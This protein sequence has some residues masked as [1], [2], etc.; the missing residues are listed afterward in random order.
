MVRMDK[1]GLPYP[2]TPEG[3]GL[4]P[5]LRNS[6]FLVGLARSNARNSGLMLREPLP[7]P[8]TRPS[9]FER[10][11]IQP[12]ILRPGSSHV[13]DELGSTPPRAPLEV[14][15]TEGAEQQLRLIEPRGVDRR[16]AIPPPAGATRQVVAGLG[17]RMGRVVIVDQV[18]ASQVTM[19]RSERTQFLDVPPGALGLEASR[20]HAPA[21]NDQEGQDIDR[22]VPRIIELALCDR[23]GDRRPGRMSFQD[24]EV[25]LLI[26]TDHPEA[27]TGQSL[28]VGVAPK[29]LLG[30]LLEPSVDAGC[31]PIP[32]AVWLEVYSME[33]VADRPSAD[34]RDDPLFDGLSSQILARPVGDMQPLGDGLQ[35]SQLNDLGPLEGGKSGPVARPV[36]AVPGDRAGR[37]SR[38][39]GRSS[40]WWRDRTGSARPVVGSAR[41]RRRP[42]GSEP[43]GFD[44]RAVTDSWRS[45]GGSGHRGGRSPGDAV[46]DHAWGDSDSWIGRDRPVYQPPRISCITSCQNH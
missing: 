22:A 7:H 5:V 39:D 14:V 10:M 13:I 4:V 42:G 29:D 25:G 21:M 8:L 28:R 12:I 6:E 11:G 41:P 40:R 3:P 2:W 46:F 9:P 1:T 23:A 43:V 32:R 44:T 31:P 37:N 36:G 18:D 16:E 38:S 35:A 20:L 34:G 24:L 26:D 19:P 27:A 17:G 33:D 45:L 15:V 30:T